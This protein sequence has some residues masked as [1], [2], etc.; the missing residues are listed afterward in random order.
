MRSLGYLQKNIFSSILFYHKNR[1][2]TR[3]FLFI[4]GAEKNFLKNFSKQANQNRFFD[5]IYTK[6][7]KTLDKSGFICYS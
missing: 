7:Q 5:T 4:D 6:E 1:A 3:A 2:L